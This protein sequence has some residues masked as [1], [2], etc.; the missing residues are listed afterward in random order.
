MTQTAHT[1]TMQHAS[2]LIASELPGAGQNPDKMQGHWV[3]ARVGKRVLRPGGI[4]LTRQMLHALA[5]SHR[6]RVV[7]FAPGLG[8]TAG[9]V[10]EKHPQAY[11]GV[12][13]EPSAARQLQQRF[14]A[15]GVRIVQASADQSGL[16]SACASMV[17]SEALLS[18]QTPQQ[19]NRIVAEACRLLGA[20]GR[21]GIHELCLLPNNM[22]D[23]L[24][25]E[26]QTE[27]SREIHVGVQP[28]CRDEWIRLFNQNGLKV[29]WS[30]EAPMRL[31]EPRRL[32]QDEGLLHSLGIAFR[33][34]TRPEL[35]SR[36][37]SMR[38]LFARYS[39][40]LGAISLVGE[41]G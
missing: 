22:P 38:R 37:R 35:G 29:T 18:M 39:K 13:R 16:P 30:S 17:Y 32:L 9:M 5:I 3:L 2:D 41:R 19:K 12:E 28:L 11:W 4:E 6:D 40:H 33:V 14:G 1:G 23:H 8:V 31:L 27:M 25:Q 34:A 10:L 7:E 26:I 15:P 24:R 36:I 20:G 21:Y